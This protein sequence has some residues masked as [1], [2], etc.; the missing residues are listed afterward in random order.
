MMWLQGAPLQKKKKFKIRMQ[1]IC[2]QKFLHT[3]ASISISGEEEC[4]TEP[5][6]S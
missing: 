1:V 5:G 6:L 2:L 4:H 3:K